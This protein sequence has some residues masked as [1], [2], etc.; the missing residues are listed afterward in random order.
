MEASSIGIAEHRLGG[1]HLRLAMFTNFSQDH[2]DY[3][4]DM[5][6]YW[7]AKEAL[8]DWPG[9]QAVVINIDDPKGVMLANNLQKNRS[10]QSLDLR[11]TRTR[12]QNDIAAHSSSES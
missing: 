1:M 5:D 7:Q 2:L 4:G 12:C 10:S 9:L 8:F 11:G 3:H 6:K